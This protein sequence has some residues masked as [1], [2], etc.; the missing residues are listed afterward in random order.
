MS[1][2]DTVRDLASFRDCRDEAIPR[3]LVGRIL[4]AGR[5]TPSPGN[6]DSL[7]FIVVEDSGVKDSLARLTGD[8]RV[9]EAPTAIVVVSDRGRMERRSG[10]EHVEEFCASEAAVA[11][12]NMRLVARENGVSSCW[13]SGFDR[14]SAA[15]ELNI[16][17]GKEPLAIV[18]LGY[19]DDEVEVEPSFLFENICFYDQYDNQLHSNFDQLQWRGAREEGRIF[20]KKLSRV[21]GDIRRKLEQVL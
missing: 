1:V 6:V 4:E 7:E 18:I 11:V 9:S 10:H 12:Q 8:E 3:K 14:D 13:I 17:H 2:F 20:R 21:A 15:D 16:P 5:N 19:S